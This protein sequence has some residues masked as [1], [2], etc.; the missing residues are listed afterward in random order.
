MDMGGSVSQDV[1]ADSN[2]FG[3]DENRD[4]DQQRDGE[5]YGDE[6]PVVGDEGPD[7]GQGP[8]H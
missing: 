2:V 8:I 1:Q 3:E 5:G 4:H 6:G 7:L